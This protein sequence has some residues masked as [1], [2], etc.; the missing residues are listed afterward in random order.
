MAP[1]PSPVVLALACALALAATAGCGP[2]LRRVHQ[3]NVYFERCYAADLDLAVP[4]TERRACWQAWHEHYQVGASPERIDHATERLAM[5]DPA[6]ADAIALATGSDPIVSSTEPSES[7]LVEIVSAEPEPIPTST[8][9]TPDALVEASD[10]AIVEPVAD[11]PPLVTT[12]DTTTH[13][14]IVEAEERAR[15]AERRSHRRIVTPRST[16]PHCASTCHPLWE[17]CTSH[18]TADEHGCVAAC[19]RE[20]T[21]CSRGCY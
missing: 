2:S 20:L 3:G 17:A 5:L 13:L 12:D 9:L 4:A 21:I 7:G 11:T 8:T 10:V 19:R 14:A 6:Q 1:R 16:S 18:C 15:A